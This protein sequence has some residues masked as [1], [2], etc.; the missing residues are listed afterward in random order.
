MYSVAHSFL[1]P[2]SQLHDTL[3]T[4]CALSFLGIC[5]MPAK[6]LPS[7]NNCPI[8]WQFECCLI[9]CKRAICQSESECGATR[10][11]RAPPA[12]CC[13]DRRCRPCK[14]QAY[15]CTIA[16]YGVLCPAKMSRVKMGLRR[17]TLLLHF[18]PICRRIEG[19]I[20]DHYHS[21]FRHSLLFISE[22]IFISNKT[23]GE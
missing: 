9:S 13:F 5:K 7:L 2:R 11:F 3:Y 10:Y 14:V 6:C 17:R 12:S 1:L 21:K 15:N 22:T 16:R 4:H 8:R 18:R 23:I 20:L 19:Q